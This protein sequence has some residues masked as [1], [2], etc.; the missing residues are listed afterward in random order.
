MSKRGPSCPRLSAGRC[1]VRQNLLPLPGRGS[2]CRFLSKYVC[3]WYWEWGG[4]PIKSNE[5]LLPLPNGRTCL[6][7]SGPDSIGRLN[8]YAR[9]LPVTAP[10]QGILPMRTDVAQNFPPDNVAPLRSPGIVRTL[11]RAALAHEVKPVT[12]VTKKDTYVIGIPQHLS[13]NNLTRTL[14]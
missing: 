2:Y 7:S 6:Y 4:I 8:N 1:L 9:R 3:Q 10:K 5:D 11:V 14:V 12:I 13:S